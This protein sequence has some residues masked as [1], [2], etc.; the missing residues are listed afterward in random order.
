MKYRI[1]VSGWWLIG[2]EFKMCLFA[3]KYGPFE[4]N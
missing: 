2:L 4:L 3:V 1:S